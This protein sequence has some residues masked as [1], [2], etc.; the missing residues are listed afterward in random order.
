[1]WEAAAVQAALA[2]VGI[3]ALRPFQ[4]E[5]LSCIHRKQDVLVVAAT[6]ASTIAAAAVAIALQA[7]VAV[8]GHARC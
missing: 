5:A 1:M 2:D 6:G 3:A 7:T 4:R 8:P